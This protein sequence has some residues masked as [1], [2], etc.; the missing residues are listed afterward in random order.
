MTWPDRLEDW[1]REHRWWVIGSLWIVVINLGF[2]GLWSYHVALGLSQTPPDPRPEPS[3]IAYETLRLF[4]LDVNLSVD[5]AKTLPLQIARFAAPL[6]VVL[7]TLQAFIVL[8]YSRWLLARSRL[9]RGHVVIAGYGRKGR[10]L[11][12]QFIDQRR[13]LVIIER[14]ED[15]AFLESLPGQGVPVV[16][17]DAADPSELYRARVHRA[18]VLVC[19]TGDDRANAQ[20]AFAAQSLAARRGGRPLDCLVYIVDPRLCTL[21]TEQELESADADLFR[22]HFF[23]PF[24]RGARIL[25]D[26]S[27]P[28]GKRE[29]KLL[30]VGFGPLSQSF[31]VQAVQAWSETSRAGEVLSITLVDREAEERVRALAAHYPAFARRCRVTGLSIDPGSARFEEA[32][33]LFDESGGVAFTRAYILLRDESAA[34]AA[35]LTLLSRLGGQRLP[36]SLAMEQENRLHEIL[37]SREQASGAPIELRVFGLL[38]RVL[39][40]GLLLGTTTEILAR[41]IHEEYVRE[42]ARRGESLE[43]NPS[44]APWERLAEDFKESNR[45]QAEHIGS[46]L[47]QV[48]CFIAPR[49]DWDEP[50]FQFTPDEI[51]TLANIEHQRFVGERLS[52]GWKYGPAKDVAKKTSPYLISWQEMDEPTRELDRNAVRNLPVLLAKVGFKIQ[53]R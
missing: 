5:H 40:P 48:L 45:R 20:V 28:F 33:F 52:Q 9:Y 49:T 2:W 25:F 46:K 29:P 50:L 41:A 34:L 38:D 26:E 11:A 8:F 36:I 24:D 22:L 43:T 7:T 3:D 23:N 44:M 6:L 17:G 51:E 18:S 27:S 10:L 39:Q 14:N 19:L 37:R 32:A 12:R 31:M 16:L 4:S 13:R 21:L 47:Q 1:W 15:N 53:R 30:V 42:Q 35:A